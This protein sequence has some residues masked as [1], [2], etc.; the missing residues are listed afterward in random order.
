[1]DKKR[2][3]EEG[4]GRGEEKNDDCSGQ[5]STAMPRSAPHQ[6]T[7]INRS[8]NRTSKRSAA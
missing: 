7:S 1:M 3:Q 4:V 5:Y 8:I 2:V 6:P